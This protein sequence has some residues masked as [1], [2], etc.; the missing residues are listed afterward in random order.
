MT[1][2]HVSRRAPSVVP[3]FGAPTTLRVL[4]YHRVDDPDSTRHLDPAL[5]SAT[6]DDFRKQMTHLVTWYRPVSLEAVARAFLRGESLP[7]RAVHV[8]FDDGYRGFR[9]IAWPI[10]R[11]LGIP[12][13]LFIA[14]A[15]P[16]NR[17]RSFWWDRLHRA[18]GRA[19]SADIEREVRRMAADRGIRPPGSRLGEVDVRKALRQLPHDDVEALVDGMCRATGV[20]TGDPGAPSVLDWNELRALGEEG[21]TFGAHTRHHASLSH[22]DPDRIRQEIRGSLDDIERELGVRP[23]SLAYP[24]GIWNRTVAR[25]AAEEGCSLAFTCQDGPNRVGHADVL[26]LRRSNITRRTSPAVFT[27]RM[28]PWFAWVERWVHWGRNRVVTT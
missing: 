11:S 28:L 7:P 14:T 4:T 20:G 26:G 23:K 15:Y 27:V 17:S 13:T 2:A 21:V 1:T 19:G 25:I 8:T 24:Y 18:R 22:A 12:V 5:I 9:D 10:L 16:G 6:P 3:R